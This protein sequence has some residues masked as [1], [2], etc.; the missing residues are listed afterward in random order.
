MDIQK[1]NNTPISVRR[2]IALVLLFVVVFLGFAV[3]LYRVQITEHAFYR[4]QARGGAT[5]TLPVAASRG[6]VLDRDLSPL[7]ANSTAYAVVLDYNYFPAGTDEAARTCQNRVIRALTDLLTARGE[8]WNDTLPISESAPYAFLEGRDTSVAELKR[9]L[10][11][12]E[13]ATAD[14]CM[15]A[16]CRRYLLEGYTPAEQRV[17]A[18]IQYEMEVREFSAFTPYVF[19]SAVSK[20]TSYLISENTVDFAGVE[21]QTAARRDYVAGRTAAHMLGTVGPIYAEEYAALKEKG[22][23]LNDTLGKS[24]VEAAFEEVLRGTAGK[25]VLVKDADGVV[26][27]AYEQE[28]PVPGDT[29]V[30]TLDAALQTAAQQALAEKVAEMRALPATS[31]GKFLNNGHD[32]ASG[33]VVVLDVT[34]GGVL[35]AA[36]WPDYDLS[37]YTAEYA[38][39]LKDPDKPLFNRALNG[40]FACGSTMKPGV[41]MA[42]LNE[43]V[44][45]ANSTFTCRYAYNRFSASGLTLHCMG[46]HGSIGTVTALQKSCNIFFYDTGLA[47]GIDT[48]NRYSSQ[49]G[50][51]EKT[52]IEI[53]EASGVL[54][55]PA[56]SAA[57]GKT[58]MPGDTAGA[59]IGQSDNL[60][61]P[62]Q[63][64][65]YAMTLA[66]DGVRY[67][68]HL[69]HGLLGYDGRMKSDY[70][71][72]IAAQLSLSEEA[73]DTVRK[74]MVAVAA[75]GTASRYFRNTPYT[76][77]CKTGTA[78]VGSNRS[79]H[80]VFIAY[81]PAEA[82]QVAMAV[83]LENGTSGASVAVARRVLDAYF[84]A[85]GDDVADAPF[86]ELL[87]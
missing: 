87:P 1:Q 66:N 81:A 32:T 63:L 22:Y 84:N 53:G 79:D 48:M 69:L 57:V 18:G 51:G 6:E 17:L 43:G 85:A 36:S 86:G 10:R 27:D 9:K 62:I 78:Q 3:R 25:R 2:L 82:P 59:A 83:V 37:A 80:G 50:L 54:A 7:V 67:K 4:E 16:L 73:I 70:E 68:T 44:I 71:P 72:Q 5:L 41:A 13:Y 49:F 55:G 29:V 24:G 56:H 47:L 61:T 34:N 77:A 42:A 52:G 46:R 76:V 23:A 28:A 31:G 74:G 14:N 40:A 15:A 75:S 12:A 64:A 20:E 19:S 58:W 11:L 39:L 38:N 33:S 60:F 30:L 26:I 65:T 45:T 21:I 35:A 8:E